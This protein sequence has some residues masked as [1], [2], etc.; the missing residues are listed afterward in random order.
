VCKTSTTY[1][2]LQYRILQ[3]ILE[4]FQ[5]SFTADTYTP[6]FPIARAFAYMLQIVCNFLPPSNRT[7]T[8]VQP[9]SRSTVARLLGLGGKHEISATPEFVELQKRH[10]RYA[11]Q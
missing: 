11:V 1:T 3:K 6:T 5:F 9:Q 10:N 8:D 2:I 4:D 7:I